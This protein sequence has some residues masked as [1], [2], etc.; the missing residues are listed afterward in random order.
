[1]TILSGLTFVAGLLPTAPC[2]FPLVILACLESVPVPDSAP[3][4]G[5]QAQ[6]GSKEVVSGEDHGASP[7]C[8]GASRRYFDPPPTPATTKCPSP[9]MQVAAVPLDPLQATHAYLGSDAHRSSAFALR[10]CRG[11]IMCTKCPWGQN[12]SSWRWRC[13]RWSHVGGARLSYRAVP[14][15][16]LAWPADLVDA[17]R[18]GWLRPVQCGCATHCSRRNRDRR[19]LNHRSSRLSP[20]HTTSLPCP[21][22]SL[23]FCWPTTNNCSFERRR[24][25][26][27]A[28]ALFSVV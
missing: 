23:V 19:P 20:L 4:G 3:A 8:G 21:S 2:L 1:M 24:A 10:H 18:F 28:Q 15:Y 5:G 27:R 14:A 12:T 25:G 22:R 11:R 6:R 26:M 7:V 17:A 13:Y 9:R 16:S